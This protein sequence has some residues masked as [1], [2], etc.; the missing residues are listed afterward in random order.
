MIEEVDSNAWPSCRDKA[1]KERLNIVEFY[2]K[3]LWTSQQQSYCSDINQ[4]RRVQFSP[5]PPD[6]YEYEPEYNR[7][8]LP[9]YFKKK[10]FQYHLGD[11]HYPHNIIHTQHHH[12]VCSN[13]APVKQLTKP[14]SLSDFRPIPNQQFNRQEKQ[15][16]SEYD[17]TSPPNLSMIFTPPTTNCTPILIESA[18][19]T[20]PTNN[21]YSNSNDPLAPYPGYSNQEEEDNS[22]RL[23]QSHYKAFRKKLVSSL[24]NSETSLL[25]KKSDEQLPEAADFKSDSGH[26]ARKFIH[27]TLQKLKYSSRSIIQRRTSVV[28]LR[29]KLSFL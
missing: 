23:K 1:P 19:S 12:T 22:T 16:S 7:G 26:T 6:I 18:V 2:H 25:I 17:L 15:H 29:K 20:V 5:N 11:E 21:D 24:R 8:L 4:K 3:V 14:R 10:K 13:K 28:T 9:K 27:C